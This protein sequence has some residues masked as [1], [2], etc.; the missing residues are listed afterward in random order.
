MLACMGNIGYVA[1]P[2]YEGTGQPQPPNFLLQRENCFAAL[3]NS[4]ALQSF[5]NISLYHLAAHSSS[6]YQKNS[7][8]S[9]KQT[10][11]YIEDRSTDTTGARKLGA[12]LV[13]DIRSQRTFTQF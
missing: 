7:C 11:Y 5:N 2:T 1:R 4:T 10:A 3:P 6:C 9:N 13:D 12:L 8:A